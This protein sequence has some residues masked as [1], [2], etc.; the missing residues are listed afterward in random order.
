MKISEHKT[1][2]F[3]L[4]YTLPL[5]FIA[6]YI[7]SWLCWQGLGNSA[8]TDGFI[9]DKSWLIAQIGVFAPS[10][11]AIFFGFFTGR[12]LP[13]RKF[14]GMISIYLAIIALGLLVSA[15][16]VSELGQLPQWIKAATLIMAALVFCYFLFQ[17]RVLYASQ[18]AGSSR[19]KLLGYFFSAWLFYPLLFF[20][21][22]AL[23]HFFAGGASI[24]LF[25][26]KGWGVFSI[27]SLT[28]AFDFLFGGAVGEE[29]GW[30]GFALP[31]LLKRFNPLKASLILGVLWSFW[32]LP[33]DLAAG[34]GV[35]G[36]GGILIRLFTVCPMSIIITW[37][38]LHSRFGIIT[39][40]LL[41]AGMNMIPALGFSNYEFVF[42]MMI[43]FQWLFVIGILVL[44]KTF[45]KKNGQNILRSFGDKESSLLHSE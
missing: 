15:Y 10:L 20:L 26:K 11:T 29:I 30:R 38:F 37:F 9:L 13:F 14:A 33:I 16:R 5:Y 28:I 31:L 21:L 22:W 3:F 2:G 42:G 18:V 17:K 23:F 8:G 44:D 6:T 19:V 34:F 7:F 32:H 41:H 40:L 4:K 25:G 39:S 45:L 36:I 35:G 24:D 43:L 1:E 27:L 12:I